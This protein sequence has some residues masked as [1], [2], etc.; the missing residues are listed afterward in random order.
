MNGYD[1]LKDTYEIIGEIGA[2]GGGVV[3]HAIHKRLKT[4]VVIKR[5]KDEVVGKLE[6]RQEVDVLKKLKHPYL[7]RVYDFIEAEDGVFTV[8]DY[9]Q[10][11]NL[12]EALSKHGKFEEKDVRKWANQ[13]GEALAYLHSQNPP[14]IHSDIKLANIMLTPEGNVCLIDFNI[15][16][17]MGN[18]ENAAVGVSA[19]FSPP[20]QY[21]DIALYERITH[22][23]TRNNYCDRQ[24]GDVEEDKTELLIQED[25]TELLNRVEEQSINLNDCKFENVKRVPQYTEYSKYIG[26]GITTKSDVYS[27]GMCLY[28]LILGEIPKTDFDSILKSLNGCSNISEGFIVILKKMLAVDPSLRYEDGNEYLNAIK[29]I[30][31]FD[32]R[33]KSMRRVVFLTN[34]IA[35]IFLLLGISLL[36]LGVYRMKALSTLAYRNHLSEAEIAIN[37]GKYEIAEQELSL[38]IEEYPMSI[39]AYEMN[40]Y[41]LFVSGQLDAC[42]ETGIAYLD[43]TPFTVMNDE[44]KDSLGDIYYIVS[45]A[46]FEQQKYIDAKT[47]IEMALEHNENNPLYNRDYAIILA[48]LNNIE[49]ANEQM[50]ICEVK[51][52]DEDSI[53]L[54]R[55]EIYSMCGDIKKATDCFVQILEK[56]TEEELGRRGVILYSEVCKKAGVNE[57]KREIE[58]LEK[59]YSKNNWNKSF[60]VSECLADAYIRNASQDNVQA[61]NYYQKALD[62]FLEI[63]ASGLCTYQLQE[64]IAILYE[65]MK[66]FDSA[67]KVLL[68]LKKDYPAKYEPLKRL[69]FLEAD[70]Q[71]QLELINRNY[72]K[73]SEYY[74]EAMNYYNPNKQDQEMEIL[75][76][77][78]KELEEGGWF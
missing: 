19:G 45:S 35:F 7:P 38:A 69:A 29:K 54:I 58:V 25:K 28:S 40:L 74:T 41:Y 72:Q 18:D 31:T 17:A 60:I 44:D 34:A 24:N 57:G 62:L 33:Y 15:S 77:L 11:M 20:E 37:T 64:N 46:F 59:Y 68:T 8:M 47:Y 12:D 6:N 23:Y 21:R 67:E 78:M 5:I 73:M 3:Y 55:G 63:Q 39:D 42:I 61:L 30:H 1:I 2:G 65:N 51:N 56:T 52:L 4:D 14:I 27:L 66:Q 49:S 36:G 9:V 43:A 50:K 26:K 13:L 16:L 10:G 71:Q 32:T 70:K 48:K 53:N 76:N 75:K 22:N